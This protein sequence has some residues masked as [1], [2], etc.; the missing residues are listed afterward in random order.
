MSR[1]LGAFIGCVSLLSD[2]EYRSTQAIRQLSL[3]IA[4][5]VA[6]RVLADLWIL[7]SFVDLP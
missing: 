1:I 7:R 5:R 3:L 2:L 4:R 6:C